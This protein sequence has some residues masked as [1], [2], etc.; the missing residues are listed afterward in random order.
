MGKKKLKS[1]TR[2]EC[3][4]CEAK[5]SKF[6]SYPAPG[7]KFRGRPVPICGQCRDQL[8]EEQRVQHFIGGRGYGK[9]R[10]FIDQLEREGKLQRFSSPTKEA[11]DE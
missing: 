5:I 8:I 3:A 10:S 7:F 9:N 11:P 1:K 4:G 2:V 6:N